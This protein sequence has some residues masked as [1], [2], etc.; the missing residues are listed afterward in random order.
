MDLLSI[1]YKH[2]R[3]VDTCRY[4]VTGEVLNGTNKS[5]LNILSNYL[6]VRTGFEANADKPQQVYS[7]VFIR[8]KHK[9]IIYIE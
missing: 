7:H 3:N 4:A 1:V 2:D 6:Y 5:V 9:M 8:L